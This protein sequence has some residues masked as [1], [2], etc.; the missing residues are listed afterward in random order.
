MEGEAERVRTFISHAE[1]L[2]RDSKAEKLRVVMKVFSER[3]PDRRR[4]VIFTESR[5]AQD[6]IRVL[7]VMKGGFREDD[8]TLFRGTNDSVRA[9]EALKRWEEEVGNGLPTHRHPSRSVAVRL[10]LVHEFRTRS[11][12]F[13]STE[14]GAKG[15]NLQFCDTIINYDLP[16]NP[17]RIEQRIGRCHRYGQ[18]HD[19]T[20]INFLAADNEAQKLTFEILSRKLDLFGK[21]LDASD[22]VLHEPSTDT[23]ETLAGAVGSD[24]EGRLRRIYERARTVGEIEAELRRLREQMEDERKRFEQTWARTAGLIESRFDQRVKQVFR[25]LQANLPEGLARLDG[26]MDELVQNFLAALGVP[27]RRVAE[28]GYIRF[29]LSPSD[30]LP[31]GWREGCIVAIGDAKKLEDAEPLHL[32][33][34]LVQAAVT[35]ARE[36]TRRLAPVVWTL[37]GSAPPELLCHKGKTGRMALIR[38]RY[39]G[40]ERVDRLV[41]LTM[42]AGESS[43]L[44]IDSARW[45][46][47][48]EPIDSPD[49]RE[50]ESDEALM[51]DVVEE[52]VFADQAQV[53]S[54]EQRRFERSLEQ[55]EQYVEDQLLVLRR[56]LG[57]ATASLRAAQDRR[58]AALGAEVRSQAEARVRTIEEEIEGI[59][60]EMRRLE[61]REDVEYERLRAD[62]HDRRYKP[63][64]VSRLL[65]VE[66]TL[67]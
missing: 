20:V 36:A 21:V 57:L 56:R 16:W 25:R 8:I 65:D 19:V 53:A 40:F 4:G 3:P 50:V 44:A 61:T 45:L 47:D 15:L 52:L 14:A 24:F 28:K 37:D 55:I 41:P 27:H 63:P 10:A 32:G 23:P 48:H 7:L 35:E 54:D 60:A 22:V 5:V 51:D 38:I 62:I 2:H 30:A 58:D 42:V 13:I 64:E 31:D 17:Q 12:I 66:F 9:V 1:T 26:A 11:R 46:L 33:H 49:F 6:Y 18:E 67:Q 43:P 59:E 29:E 39:D 34:A